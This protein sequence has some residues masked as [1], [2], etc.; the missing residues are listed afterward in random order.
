MHGK[1]RINE[2]SITPS[3]P[4]A[5]PN[6]FKKSDT[7][8]S[9]LLPS[10]LTED[11]IKIINP[12]GAAT[13]TALSNILIV[14]SKIDLTITLNIWGFLYGGSSKINDE[15]SPFNKV[16]DNIWDTI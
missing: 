4:I 12:A 14:L 7:I 16:R 9:K 2:S 5:S 11:K 3:K 1:P 8:L 6:G 13:A 10:I 15:G